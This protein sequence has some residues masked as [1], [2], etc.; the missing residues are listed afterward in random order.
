MEDIGGAMKSL[1]AIAKK[2]QPFD[3]DVIQADG[4]TRCVALNAG[5]L[6]TVMV[7]KHLV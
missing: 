5:M 4:S 7:L 3:A 6:L 1:A 2:E